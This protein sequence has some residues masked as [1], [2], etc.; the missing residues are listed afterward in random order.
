[1]KWNGNNQY[2]ILPIQSAMDHCY[3]Q[4]RFRLEKQALMR[5]QAK[6]TPCSPV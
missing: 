3:Q 4:Q 1:M 5:Q 2:T 6:N